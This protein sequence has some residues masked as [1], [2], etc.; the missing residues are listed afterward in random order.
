MDEYHNETIVRKQE[1][2]FGTSRDSKY[3]Y[4]SSV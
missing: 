2:Q 1:A 4:I 3:L